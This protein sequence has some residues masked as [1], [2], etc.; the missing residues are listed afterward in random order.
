MGCVPPSI[1]AGLSAG[2]SGI[3]FWGWNLAGFNG[4]LPSAELYLLSAAMAAFCPVMQYHSE[5]N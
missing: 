5:F 1:L 4:E 2:I 3:S